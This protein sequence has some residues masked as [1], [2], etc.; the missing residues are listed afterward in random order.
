M[1]DT[2]ILH[3]SIA[4]IIIRQVGRVCNSIG[5]GS[6]G[7]VLGD[8]HEAYGCGHVPLVSLIIS[9]RL[10]ITSDSAVLDFLGTAGGVQGL[11]AFSWTSQRAPEEEEEQEAQQ[12]L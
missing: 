10:G 12:G 11:K 4:R 9:K 2:S 7:W 8:G 6:H 1:G 3:Q 5:G